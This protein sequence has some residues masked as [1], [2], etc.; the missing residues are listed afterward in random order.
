[1]SLGQVAA[2]LL[3]GSLVVQQPDAGVTTIVP[4]LRW[5]Y[6]LFDFVDVDVDSV[7]HARLLWFND[8]T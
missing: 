1:V 8:R 3:G 5:L 2:Y 7:T 4:V 6:R